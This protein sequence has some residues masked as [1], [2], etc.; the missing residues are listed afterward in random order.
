MENQTG[1]ARPTIRWENHSDDGSVLVDHTNSNLPSA[2]FFGLKY[3]ILFPSRAPLT[4][5]HSS[6]HVLV[7]VDV[8]QNLD[9]VYDRLGYN[10]YLAR[11]LHYLDLPPGIYLTQ[12]RACRLDWIGL[13]GATLC[14][15]HVIGNMSHR[16]PF[17]VSCSTA[18][19]HWNW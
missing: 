7:D 9:T 8:Q 13:D 5:W 16:G 12:T 10:D 15:R 2:T 19:L 1:S 11:H 6:W 14:R 3:L 17:R 4:T 18:L